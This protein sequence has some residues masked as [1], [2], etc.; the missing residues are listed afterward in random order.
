M[1]YRRISLANATALACLVLGC[2]SSPSN[3]TD[4]EI[5]AGAGAGAGGAEA[6]GTD[7]TDAS[8]F[9]AT[10][11]RGGACW[12]DPPLQGNDIN[13]I[14]A[15]QSTVWAVAAGGVVLRQK[16][17]NWRAANAP[18]TLELYGVWAAADDDVWAVGARGTIVHWDGEELA[19]IPSPTEEDLRSVWGVGADDVWA[20][21]GKAIVHW[22]GNDWSPAGEAE[23]L[24]AVWAAGPDDVW[25][26][27]DSGRALHGKDGRWSSEQ[28]AAHGLLA[29]TGTGPRPRHLFAGGYY[30][31]LVAN[32]GDR[33]VSE[34]DGSYGNTRSLAFD[35]SET[36]WAG[37]DERVAYRG[38]TGWR[39]VA[40]VDGDIRVL[41]LA[42]A[43]GADGVW[44]A[45]SGGLLGRAEQS[46]VEWQLPAANI[47]DA[48][49]TEG[50]ARVTSH[51]RTPLES[52]LRWSDES[53]AAVVARLSTHYVVGSLADG[54]LVL[55]A[56][57]IDD[58]FD[59]A[60]VTRDGLESLPTVANCYG[61]HLDPLGNNAHDFW[62]PHH[63]GASHWDGSEWTRH[64]FPTPGISLLELALGRDGDLWALVAGAGGVRSARFDG[65][66]WTFD[67]DR[68]PAGTNLT[69]IAVVGSS[70][71][72]AGV[73]RDGLLPTSRSLPVLYRRERSA[74]VAVQLPVT[75]PPVG[76]VNEVRIA[77]DGTKLWYAA[78]EGGHFLPGL[79][80]FDG[81]TWSQSDIPL[82]RVE[83]LF[84]GAGSMWLLG[85]SRHGDF[86]LVKVPLEIGG[87]R[88]KP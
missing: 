69:G 17:G 84:P 59:V 14:S 61:A 72:A 21:G 63:D 88:S 45:G 49:V 66:E 71:Y 13:A 40:S 28:V 1:K 5:L 27:D 26:V 83:K 20:V 31:S 44:A 39:D 6:N 87:S 15:T 60:I 77:T 65:S 81:S 50:G 23:G 37:V 36:L 75:A 11:C 57:R 10:V 30:G 68:F 29:L 43:R 33:W 46:G 8:P 18:S 38:A 67:P 19:A 73:H 22:D 79:L 80:R 2:G 74:W 64:Y 24:T 34:D 51:R 3:P 53:G 70:V 9:S 58:S 48:W 32:G 52:E 41:A 62:L 86:G 85:G 7:G 16:D 55:A 54:Q 47:V 4:G 25:V 35:A 78:A 12:V 56:D 82:G 42:A 76:G